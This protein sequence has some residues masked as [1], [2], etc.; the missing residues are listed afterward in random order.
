MKILHSIGLI[1]SS[2]LVCLDWFNSTFS[3]RTKHARAT[4]QESWSV[5]FYS[6]GTCNVSAVSKLIYIHTCSLDFF[7][8]EKKCFRVFITIALQSTLSIVQFKVLRV[9]KCKIFFKQKLLQIFTR[10]KE[11]VEKLAVYDNKN[12]I[13]T[14]KLHMLHMTKRY[15]T[16]KMCYIDS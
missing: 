5:L 4:V 7:I 10:C 13:F 3:C 12:A 16:L 1:K 6:A 11:I 2:C 8:D 9:P 15:T 14:V